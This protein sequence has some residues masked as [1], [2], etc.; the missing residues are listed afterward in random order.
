MIFLFTFYA[1][2]LLI[3]FI[4]LLLNLVCIGFIPFTAYV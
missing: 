1:N 2:D 3:L 4:T